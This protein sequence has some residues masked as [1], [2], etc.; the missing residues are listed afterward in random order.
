MAK[1]YIKS[2]DLEWI[3]F[4]LAGDETNEYDACRRAIHECTTDECLDEY[5]YCD[6]RGFRDY[7]TADKHTY[8]VDTKEIARKEGIM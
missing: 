6:E 8:V 4:G 5:M 2:A 1:Y 3:Y 7:I